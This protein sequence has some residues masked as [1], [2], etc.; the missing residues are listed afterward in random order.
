MKDHFLSSK[1]LLEW[2]RFKPAFLGQMIYIRF[3]GLEVIVSEDIFQDGNTWRHV[4]M[5]HKKKLPS[6]KEMCLVKK[7][8]I[9]D[10]KAIQVF[11]KKSE[12]VNIHSFCLHLYCNLDCDNIPDFTM[13]SGSI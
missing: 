6:Y 5:A 9:G 8:F 10:R 2:K 1:D 4:S 11:P 13:G 7:L 12:H 3:T